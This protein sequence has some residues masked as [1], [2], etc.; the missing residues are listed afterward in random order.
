VTPETGVNWSTRSNSLL[1]AP[2]PKPPERNGGG[3]DGST[4]CSR[5]WARRERLLLYTLLLAGL[6]LPSRP[7][8]VIMSAAG[9]V[10]VVAQRAL[11]AGPCSLSGTEQDWSTGEISVGGVS[12]ISSTELTD[13]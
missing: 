1:R 6:T 8:V 4:T 3:L 13:Q 11:K 2:Q 5:N 7:Y 10:A 9:S 12:L